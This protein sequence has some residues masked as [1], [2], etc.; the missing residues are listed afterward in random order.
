MTWAFHASETMEK[1]SELTMFKPENDVI[2]PIKVSRL[3]LESIIQ[4]PLFKYASPAEAQLGGGRPGARP[5]L[6]PERGAPPPPVE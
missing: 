1:I 2:D 5:P 6:A 4:F 3:P